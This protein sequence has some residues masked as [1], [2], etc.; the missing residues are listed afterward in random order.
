[1]KNDIALIYLEEG[2]VPDEIR[3]ATLPAT[4][5]STTTTITT[6]GIGHTSQDDV[7]SS[8]D[9]FREAEMQILSNSQRQCGDRYSLSLQLDRQ[10]CANAPGQAP[11]RGDSGGPAIFNDAIVGIISYGACQVNVPTVFTKVQYYLPWIYQSICAYQ[12]SQQPEDSNWWCQ[13][14]MEEEED[15]EP[16]LLSS[17]TRPVDKIE[18][19]LSAKRQ[20]SF[21]GSNGGGSA[22]GLRPPAGKKMDT[23]ND[24]ESLRQKPSESI[25]IY[26]SSDDGSI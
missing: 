8:W 1:M 12:T 5:S 22:V 14:Q 6:I 15:D 26:Q 4:S 13:Q 7:S 19:V 23:N 18:T 24:D 25:S 10:F 16:G 9:Q 3:I 2:A 20:A 17:S 11:C 21:F